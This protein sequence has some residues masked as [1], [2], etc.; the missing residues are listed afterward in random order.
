MNL[1][2]SLQGLP[3]AN[4]PGAILNALRHPVL[5]VDAENQVSYANAAA[6]NFFATSAAVLKRNRLEAYVPFSSPLLSLLDQVRR[7]GASI[8]EYDV[9]IGT[10]QS[11]ASRLVDLQVN[12]VADQPNSCVILLQERSMAQKIER[13]LSHRS[14]ARS[15]T[16]MAS[17]LA[18]EIKNPLSGIRGAAQLL[19]MAVDE[20]NQALTQLICDETDRICT[21]V[22]QMEVF[23][24]ERPL[25]A[26]PVN[27]H[28]VLG[29]V[30]ALASAGFAKGLQISEVYDPSLPQTAGNSDQLIQVLLN[31]VKNAAEAISGAAG[32]GDIRLVTSYRP[33]I[34]MSV[35]GS[36]GKVS[37]PL[38]I[39]VE[40]SG[41]GI[42]PDL[43]PH[44]FEPFVT[45]RA[46]GKGLGLALV[47]KIVRDHGGVIEC[48]SRPG[49]TAFRLLLP[50]F[51]ADLAETRDAAE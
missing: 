13:Q 8:N 21:L 34:R 7:A 6:E 12:P 1:P 39:R 5:T 35:A 49:K 45:S 38:E 16:G 32:K 4:E 10:P 33:G 37:L 15:V 20:D 25:E 22:D 27:I 51:N 44:L 42:P 47:A 36:P 26:E 24:D 30:K 9:D 43:I 40:D 2:A 50:L 31:L 3:T 14:A 18:H 11:G 29:Y 41:P 48:D 19:G 28:V 23:S 17:M 46:Q